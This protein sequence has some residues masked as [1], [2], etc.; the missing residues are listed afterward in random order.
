MDLPIY[1]IRIFFEVIWNLFGQKV[2]D[3]RI[4]EQKRIDAERLAALPPEGPT[5][6]QR[7]VELKAW[8]RHQ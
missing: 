7:K 5:L 2:L 1:L 6:E 3:P 8:I 4:V